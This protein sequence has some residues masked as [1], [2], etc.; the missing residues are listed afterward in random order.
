MP[1]VVPLVRLDQELSIE[2]SRVM[3]DRSFTFNIP[4][5]HNLVIK[6]SGTLSSYDRCT[7]LF[8]IAV[9]STTLL[10]HSLYRVNTYPPRVYCYL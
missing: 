6:D 9:V 3:N 4:P 2:S 8:T 1:L 5:V 7:S 10:A